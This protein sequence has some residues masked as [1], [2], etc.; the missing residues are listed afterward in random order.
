MKKLVTV[1]VAAA[2]A[3]SA[4]FAFAGLAPRSGVNDSLHDMNAY[5]LGHAA[6]EEQ[7]QRV[8]V[9]CHTPH[10]AVVKDPTDLLSVKYLPLWNHDFTVLPFNT[11]QWATPDNS[12]FRIDDALVGPSRLC[13]SCHD[14]ATAIDQHGPSETTGGTFG[15]L[16]G[17][18]AVG[19][20]GDVSDD[21]P[22]GFDY[23][24]AK[25]FRNN[26][27]VGGTVTPVKEIVDETEGFAVSVDPA[28]LDP[29]T[30][31]NRT[32]TRT[33]ASTLYM[34]N[35]MTCASCHEVHNKENA[36]QAPATFGAY[37][38]NYFLYAKEQ[39]SLICLSCH[40]K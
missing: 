9:Y 34:G 35:M 6:G 39:Y 36:T 18:R 20:N 14:G 40:V 4:T 22:I 12:G 3:A 7:F 26:P 32:S 2:V 17:P 23:I 11:Y 25:N 33:I 37:Q 30:K 1:L 5:K 28:G 27:V 8:C 10:N 31:V 15:A 38:P 19:R 24:A 21:H 13:M 16:A 29:Y